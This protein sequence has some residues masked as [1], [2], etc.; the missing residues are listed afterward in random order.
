MPGNHSAH[1][2]RLPLSRWPPTKDPTSLGIVPRRPARP[3]FAHR[4][5]KSAHAAPRTA[6]H[7]RHRRA[8]VLK[9]AAIGEAC[10]GRRGDGTGFSGTSLSVRLTPSMSEPRVGMMHLGIHEDQRRLPATVSTAGDL[11]Q[12]CPVDRLPNR[13]PRHQQSVAHPGHLTRLAPPPDISS[14]E[15]GASGRRE[16]VLMG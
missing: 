15:H 9:R 6:A 7:S 3:R 16:T 2:I 5:M 8:D 14:G 13:P 12:P 11:W 1:T 4:K 10:L